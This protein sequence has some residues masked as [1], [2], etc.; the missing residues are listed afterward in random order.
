MV[1]G[2]IVG[3]YADEPEQPLYDDVQEKEEV[4]QPMYDDLDGAMD[5]QGEAI[6]DAAGEAQV[7]GVVW[8]VVFMK[9]VDG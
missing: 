8:G 1:H 6:Y 2:A 7:R 3:Y 9:C 5:T 4:E